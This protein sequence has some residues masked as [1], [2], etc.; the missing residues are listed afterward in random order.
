MGWDGSAQ[1]LLKVE[2][3]REQER[4]GGGGPG[5]ESRRRKACTKGKRLEEGGDVEIPSPQAGRTD[6]SYN[7]FFFFLVVVLL[8]LL[9]MEGASEPVSEGW[10][11]GGRIWAESASQRRSLFGSRPRWGASR[12]HGI[13]VGVSK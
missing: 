13:S 5:G 4:R 1:G 2:G 10:R 7:Y 11:E 9:A 3:E 12:E 6:Y 8:L